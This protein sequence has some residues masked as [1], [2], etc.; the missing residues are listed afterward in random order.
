LNDKFEPFPWASD[1]E[2][3]LY[4]SSDEVIAQPVLYTGPPPAPAG[5]YAPPT[6]P[7][8]STLVSAIISSSTSFSLSLIR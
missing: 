3:R 8:I 2:R 4:L 5:V 1:E 6:I 7:P